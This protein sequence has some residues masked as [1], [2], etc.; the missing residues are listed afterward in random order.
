MK[1]RAGKKLRYRYSLEHFPTRH[2]A[3]W[4]FQQFENSNQHFYKSHARRQIYSCVACRHGKGNVG[5]RLKVE[6]EE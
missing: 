4:S 1:N 3:R 2:P 6:E 5:V